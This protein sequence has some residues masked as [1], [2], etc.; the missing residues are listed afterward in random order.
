MVLTLDEALKLARDRGTGVALAKGRVEEALARET[1]AGRR[2]QEN[3]SVELNGGYRHRRTEGDFLDFEAILSQG[4]YAGPLPTGYYFDIGGTGGEPGARGLHRPRPAQ[5]DD[6]GHRH[7]RP[8]A[9]PGAPP[10]RLRDRA[11]LAV[12]MIGGLLTSTLFTLLALPTFYQ[13]VHSWRERGWLR[14]DHA[15]PGETGR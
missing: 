7:P 10:P 3:P 11:A 15:S 14:R 8:A 12:V 1:Q 4:L 9:A 13:W 2:F 5:A 6:R